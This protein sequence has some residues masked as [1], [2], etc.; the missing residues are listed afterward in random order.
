MRKNLNSEVENTF[1][2]QA[3]IQRLLEEKKEAEL[4]SK[5]LGLPIS[6]R[7]GKNAPI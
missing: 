7:L 5:I 6:M 3:S 4:N 1:Y 2:M